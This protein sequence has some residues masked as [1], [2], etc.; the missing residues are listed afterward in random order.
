MKK[1]LFFASFVFSLFMLSACSTENESI[2]LRQTSYSLSDEN[3]HKLKG[4]VDSISNYYLS[5]HA[6]ARTRANGDLMQYY[7][8]GDLVSSSDDAGRVVGKC[9]G[10]YFG[11]YVGGLSSPIGG[12]LGSIIGRRVGAFAGGVSAS[13]VTFLLIN[14]KYNQSNR[15]N[16]SAQANDTVAYYLPDSG[17]EFNDSIGY[18][19]NLVMYKL[20]ANGDKY[21]LENKDF[22]YNLIY[23]D[24]IAYLNEYG[25]FDNCQ[26]EMV[27]ASRWDF[28]DA[29]ISYVKNT[30][31]ISRNFVE[32]KITK[33]EFRT[34]LMRCVDNYGL[35][36]EERLAISDYAV[37][38]SE[39]CSQLSYEA[40]V[41]YA[42]DLNY[43]ISNS[44]ISDELK[45]E[46]R[47]TTNM[48]VNSTVF[49]Q[50]AE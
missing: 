44:D 45:S 42:D 15:L 8:D 25:V 31:N 19:H 29:V 32:G 17:N 35:T 10:K 46:L 13:F 16:I 11:A 30:S 24:C 20:V 21:V 37:K 47:S 39:T 38:L 6:L 18:Y 49:C 41:Q 43:M 48:I 50:M 12:I 26:E 40:N 22:D 28:K 5:N 3:Y 27:V 33:V 23:N 1:V 4:K 14:K 34:Q 9:I 2:D 36:D 7:D